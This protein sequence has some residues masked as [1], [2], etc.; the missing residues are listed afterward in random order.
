[1]NYCPKPLFEMWE[2]MRV[3]ISK[4]GVSKTDMLPLIRGFNEL[5]DNN[6][7]Y[8]EDC[9]NKGVSPYK[10]LLFFYDYLNSED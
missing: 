2:A 8:F 4:Y 9:M 10:G 1:M 7:D 3:L 5:V 6:L